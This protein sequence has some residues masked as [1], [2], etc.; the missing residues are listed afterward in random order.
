MKQTD[1]IEFLFNL[2]QDP[3]VMR[4]ITNGKTTSR[5]KL[6]TGLY[7]AL[8]HLPKQAKA[9]ACGVCQI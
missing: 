3:N 4:Y 2:D 5:E 7:R 6:K 8:L 1:D 9:G